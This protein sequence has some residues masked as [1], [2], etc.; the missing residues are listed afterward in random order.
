MICGFVCETCANIESRFC[1]D[2][3]VPASFFF[4]AFTSS[5]SGL[6]SLIGVLTKAAFDDQKRPFRR[7]QALSL[8]L[9]AVK[10][11]KLAPAGGY[12]VMK[13]IVEGASDVSIR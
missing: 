1:S 6:D 5:W 8:L 9:M 4:P 10:Q 13:G 12:D 3:V 11:A 7:S 2:S